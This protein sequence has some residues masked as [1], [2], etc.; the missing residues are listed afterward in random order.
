MNLDDVT[1]IIPVYCPTK[2][3]LFWFEECLQSA[4][5]QGCAISVWDDGSP[6]MIPY[7]VITDKAK[8]YGVACDLGFDGHHGVSHA[9]NMA[10]TNAT[11][12]LIVPLDC[13][14]VLEASAISTILKAWDGVPVYPD[15][16]KFGSVERHVFELLD[17]SCENIYKYAG[18]TSVNVLHLKEQWESIGGYDE[19]LDFYEDSEYNAR[20]FLKY[21][22][23]HCKIPLVKYRIHEGQRTQ[24]YKDKASLYGKR[25]LDMI[26]GYDMACSGC[27]GKRRTGNLIATSSAVVTNPDNMPATNGTQVLVQYIGGNGRGYHYYEG[28]SSHTRYKV[29][30][31]QYL[32]ADPAD[33]RLR[34]ETSNRSLL[35][36]YEQPP[37]APAPTIIER[38]VVK[39]AVMQ[40]YAVPVQEEPAKPVVKNLPDIATMSVKQIINSSDITPDNAAEL[41]RIERNGLSRSKVIEYLESLH[42]GNH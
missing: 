21:C 31:G 27:G 13:D 19:K 32:Y 5:E 20:L 16:I 23:V 30:F 41:A 10:I 9:R 12:K 28:L 1:I 33:A 38:K 11:T 40:D 37:V 15:I 22:G 42:N 6:F 4:L 2:T 14:D 24:Q 34:T 36:R 25:V 39:A 3:S 26:G 8:E 17:F 18:F 35:V 29:T 7:N